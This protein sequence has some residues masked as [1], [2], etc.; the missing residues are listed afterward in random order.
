MER[1]MKYADGFRKLY[2]Q[3]NALMLK[4]EDRFLKAMEGFPQ[5]PDANCL[6]VYGY[7]DHEQGLT[8][9]ILAMGRKDD[10]AFTFAE[11]SHDARVITR[12][13]AL[14]DHEFYPVDASYA[15]E[16][17]KKIELLKHYDVSPEIEQTR[18]MEFLDESREPGYVDDVLVY[19]IKD[20]L[21]VEACW[22]RIEKMKTPHLVGTLLN[23][24]NQ[25]FGCHIN[26]LVTFSVRRMGDG[27]VVCIAELG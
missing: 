15:E 27:K 18:F 16:H 21:D 11:G 1:L 9:E 14:L 6:L 4:E 8:F 25:D 12:A 10:D 17:S 19:F 22:V 23:E 3:C 24:P 5:M 7:I 2:K 13:T 20:E 26:D